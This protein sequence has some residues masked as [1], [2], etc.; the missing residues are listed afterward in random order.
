M[1]CGSCN[2][3]YYLPSTGDKTKCKQCSV[4]KCKVCPDDYCSLCLGENDNN[5]E[6][7]YPYLTEEMALKTVMDSFNVYNFKDNK[8]FCTIYEKPDNPK[9]QLATYKYYIWNRYKRVMIELEGEI[10]EKQDNKNANKNTISYPE[11]EYIRA[12][13]EGYEFTFL[14]H[15]YTKNNK[16][17]WRE[18]RLSE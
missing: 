15:I 3:G 8:I 11:N 16:A 13:N 6:I 4:T 7:N 14:D 12:V 2:E 9:L 1:L 5:D 17:Y 10:C 18:V